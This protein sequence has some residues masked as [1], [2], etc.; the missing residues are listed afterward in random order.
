[1]SRFKKG[2]KVICDIDAMS[3]VVCE[4]V[5]ETGTGS[6]VQHVVDYLGRQWRVNEVKRFD[7]ITQDRIDGFA[8][9][10]YELYNDLGKALIHFNLLELA[11]PLQIQEEDRIISLMD[12]ALDISIG[13]RRQPCIGRIMEMPCWELTAHRQ[14]LGT[15]EDPPDVVDSTVG[16]TITGMKMVELVIGTLRK[17]QQDAYFD[18]LAEDAMAE[19]YH[20]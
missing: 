1:M 10:I 2:D 7:A 11:G 8:R 15:R 12:G 6:F 14:T 13:V 19:E 4:Y 16:Q 3:G 9:G 17:M 18:R 5:Q 20:G